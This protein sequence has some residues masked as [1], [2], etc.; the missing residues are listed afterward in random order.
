MQSDKDPI[1]GKIANYY[2]GKLAE[3]G[4]SARGVDWNSEQS[5][6]LRYEQL[7]R[8]IDLVGGFSINDLGCGYGGYFDYLARKYDRIQYNGF[9]LSADMI[10]AAQHRFARNDCARFMVAGEP[11]SVVDFGIASGIFNVRLDSPGDS[12]SAHVLRT[13]DVMNSTSRRG[14]A[15]NCL[16]SYSDQEKMRDYL[17]YSNPGNLFDHCK[18]NYSHNVALLHDYGLYEFTILVRKL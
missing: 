3:H 18:R 12:W 16:T 10:S 15:F 14:F 13:L 6:V 17:Y 4:P 9:D 2:S 5:Q 7:S 1:L 8:V 11:D